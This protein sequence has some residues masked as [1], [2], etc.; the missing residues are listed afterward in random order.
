MC[1]LDLSKVFMYEFHY[2]YIKNKYGNNSILLL[3][4][5]ES[6]MYEI[7]VEDVYED[8][9]KDRRMFNFS[10]YSTKSKYYDNSN[11]WVVGKMKGKTDGGT[12]KEF[13]RLKPKMYSFLVDDIVSI[14][15]GMI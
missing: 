13:V 6:L 14:K 4:D 12:I 8:F 11:K 15:Q 10:N 1:I 9:I 7:K 5:T 3:N 2:D